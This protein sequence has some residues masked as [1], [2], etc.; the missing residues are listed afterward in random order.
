MFFI[1]I[2][3]TDNMKNLLVTGG[4]GYIGS[5]AVLALMEKG[6]KVVVLDNLSRGYVEAINELKKIGD[7][8]FVT[9]DLRDEAL[10]DTLFT[11]YSIDTVLHFAAFCTPDESVSHPGMYYENNVGG[12]ATL[13]EAMRRHG[14]KKIIFSSTCATYGETKKLPV[15][16]THPQAPVNPY[17]H[18]KLLAEEVIAYYARL[19][20]MQYVIF[21]YFNVCGCDAEGRIGDSKRPS[22]LLMQNA[23]RGALGL[24]SF[25]YTCPPASTPDGT[26]IRDYIDVRDLVDAHAAAVS[27]LDRGGGSEAFNLGTGRGSSVKE[28][29][30][31]VEKYLKIHIEKSSVPQRQGEYDEIYADPSKAEKSLNWKAY[32]SLED[33]I[34]GLVAWYTKHPKGYHN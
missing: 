17:G 16:E 29:V 33:S 20:N 34:S 27:Y 22:Q 25:G 24:D 15:D 13:L 10:L 1:A 30:S 31:A 18:S 23:I 21:R 28:I 14:I 3:Y 12:T 7:L 6:Y 19:Y 4:A 9:G 26:P 32:R 11:N 5:H 8:E 2:V